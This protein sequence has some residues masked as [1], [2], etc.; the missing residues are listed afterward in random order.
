[1]IETY[2]QEILSF[3]EVSVEHSE[4]ENTILLRLNIPVTFF[5]SGRDFNHDRIFNKNLSSANFQKNRNLELENGFAFLSDQSGFWV[6]GQKVNCCQKLTTRRND[7][8]VAETY[9][10]QE[11]N[12]ENW[13]PHGRN[14]RI[15]FIKETFSICVPVDRQ[16]YDNVDETV[17]IDW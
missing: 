12:A 1:M 6:S 8:P 15:N 14:C 9:K 4:D 17:L 3:F 7:I 10:G 11:Q 16:H 2:S 13:D 5:V